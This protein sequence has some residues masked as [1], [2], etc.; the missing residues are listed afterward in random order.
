M[1]VIDTYDII[2]DEIHPEEPLPSKFLADT[3]YA[4]VT[5]PIGMALIPN[6]MP[7]FFGQRLIKGCIHDADFDDKMESISP[8]HLKWAKLFKEHIAQK[9]NDSDDIIKIVDRSNKKSKKDVNARFGT[10]GF[11]DAYKSDSCFFFTYILSNGDKWT[12][13]QAKLREFF[14]GN[15]SPTMNPRSP[16]DPMQTSSSQNSFSGVNALSPNAPPGAAAV[17]FGFVEEVLHLLLFP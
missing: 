3:S 16:S 4:K 5:V 9:E 7:I 11:I 17:P 15:P 10:A 6:V 12:Q 2:L 13:H 1:Y 14:V 8:I